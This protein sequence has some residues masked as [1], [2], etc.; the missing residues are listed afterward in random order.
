LQVTIIELQGSGSGSGGTV[1]DVTGT[2]PIVITSTPTTTPNV[3]ISPAT[4]SAAGSMSAADKTK[5]D[6]GVAITPGW[7]TNSISIGPNVAP[8]F[9]TGNITVGPT[10]NIRWTAQMTV[11]GSGGTAIAGDLI[12][13]NALLDGA[14]SLGIDGGQELGDTHETCSCTIVGHQGGLTPGATHTV[15]IQAVDSTNGTRTLSVLA[16]G[17]VQISWDTY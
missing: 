1:T 14:A 11:S 10:G 6:A 15:G 3:T 4:D 16:A 8:S 9:S 17:Q 2:A 5:L 12:Q 13:F 7:V